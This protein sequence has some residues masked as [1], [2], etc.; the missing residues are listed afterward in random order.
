MKNKWGYI[1]A[2]GIALFFAYR[3]IKYSRSNKSVPKSKITGTVS[4]S[5]MAQEYFD[6]IQL[7]YSSVPP[8]SQMPD[9]IKSQ[10]VSY[11]DKIEQNGFT[12]TNNQLVKL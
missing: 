2:T 6:K 8:G 11:M 3:Y 5:K 1:I 7:L 10:V 4:N 9:Q 12:V